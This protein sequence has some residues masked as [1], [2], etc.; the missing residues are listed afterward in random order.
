VH[1]LVRL[2]LGLGECHIDVTESSQGIRVQ[3]AGAL[4]KS[5]LQSKKPSSLD[6][7]NKAPTRLQQRSKLDKKEAERVIEHKID[8]KVAQ[9]LLSAPTLCDCQWQCWSV[10]D[11]A[12]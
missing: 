4:P 6:G 1:G 3:Y 11:L 9:R 2:G 10:A 7:S 5:Y 8:R 12:T